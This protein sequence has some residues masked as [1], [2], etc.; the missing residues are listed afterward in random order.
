GG[1]FTLN[2]TPTS[3]NIPIA[4]TGTVTIAINRTG[5]VGDVMLSAQNLPSGI[6]ATFAANPVPAPS[7]STDVTFSA[8]PGQPAGSPNVT[9]VVSANGCQQ[10]VTVTVSAQTIT[11]TGTIRSGA[12]GVTV[13]LVGKTAVMSG[14]GGAFTFTNVSPPYDLY[15]VGTSGFGTLTAPTVF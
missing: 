8:A 14:A 15:T 1:S 12:Q 10:T 6:T 13:G 9:I 11:V 5:S 2:A 7:S 4:S 3:V